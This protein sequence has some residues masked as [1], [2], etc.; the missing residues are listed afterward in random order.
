MNKTQRKTKMRTQ[1]SEEAKKAVYNQMR[2]DLKRLERERLIDN[3]KECLV[4]FGFV[5]II[6]FCTW[7]IL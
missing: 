5:S 6:I 3:I 1:P 2:L 4:V 7:V